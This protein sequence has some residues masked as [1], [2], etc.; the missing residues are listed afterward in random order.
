[1]VVPDYSMEVRRKHALL[2]A[3]GADEMTVVG[4]ATRCHDAGDIMTAG[5]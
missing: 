5:D 2:A 1:M 3:H 4:K